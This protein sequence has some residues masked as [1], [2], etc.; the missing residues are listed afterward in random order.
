MHWVETLTDGG[1]LRQMYRFARNGEGNN[2]KALSH[3]NAKPSGMGFMSSSIFPLLPVPP[4]SVCHPSFLHFLSLTPSPTSPVSSSS[5][6]ISLCLLPFSISS[7]TCPSF[8]IL[9]LILSL[10]PSPFP[11]PFSS[12]THLL[13]LPS[14]LFF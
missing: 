13:F 3:V 7:S 6:S 11:P 9:F 14:C 4:H 1:K 2:E 5:P 12:S 8:Y 10:F